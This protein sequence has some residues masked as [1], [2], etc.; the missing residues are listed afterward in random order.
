MKIFTFFFLFLFRAED[1]KN[2]EFADIIKPLIQ[3]QEQQQQTQNNNNNNYSSNHEDSTSLTFSTTSS[4]LSSLHS[5][6]PML[7]ITINKL[8][9]KDHHDEPKWE[10]IAHKA[11]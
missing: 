1:L 9:Q 4:T 8:D 3:Q 11:R 2:L 5:N 7:K 10:I 6:A